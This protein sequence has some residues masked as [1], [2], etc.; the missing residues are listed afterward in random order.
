MNFEQLSIPGLNVASIKVKNYFA[1]DS[2]MRM[3][4][5]QRKCIHSKPLVTATLHCYK[6]TFYEPK[7]KATIQKT[8]RAANNHVYGALYEV[9]KVDVK[10]LDKAH[11]FPEKSKKI[12]VIVIDKYGTAHKAFTYKLRKQKQKLPTEKYLDKIFEAYTDWKL[13]PHTLFSFWSE[14]AEDMNVLQKGE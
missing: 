14:T 7:G 5:M 10:Q 13:H 6:M 8:T 3:S 1:Y 11:G 2:T 9:T 4:Y 12:K